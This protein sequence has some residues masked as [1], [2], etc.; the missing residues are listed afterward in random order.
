MLK[1][2][3]LSVIIFQRWRKLLVEKVMCHKHAMS[4][5]DMRPL[6]PLQNGALNTQKLSLKVSQ[7]S[8]PKRCP[9]NCHKMSPVCE[10]GWKKGTKERGKNGWK[11]LNVILIGNIVVLH[12]SLVP[13]ISDRWDLEKINK[14][15]QYNIII[16]L[17]L[18]SGSCGVEVV[19]YDN[20]IQQNFSFRENSILKIRLTLNRYFERRCHCCNWNDQTYI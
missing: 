6:L 1:K 7:K 14:P 20:T 17:I 15:P 9:K 3:L 4:D 18:L 13:I 12:A 11:W 19:H 8:V 10:S 5:H 16:I 2:I